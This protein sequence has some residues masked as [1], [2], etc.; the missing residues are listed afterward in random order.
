MSPQGVEI[1]AELARR[2]Q[3]GDAEGA[4]RLFHPAIRVEQPASLPHGGW[5]DGHVGMAAMGAI[6][7]SLWER[8]VSN[9][10]F[11]A[12]AKPSSR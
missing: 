8:S 12:A 1:V 4:F 2:F 5:H 7:A 11:S 10:G 3:A 9:P 6:F